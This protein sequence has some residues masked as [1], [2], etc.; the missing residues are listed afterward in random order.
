MRGL[1]ARTALAS[2]CVA[3]SLVLAFLAVYSDVTLSLTARKKSA[4]H[5]TLVLQ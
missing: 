2:E 4:L 3:R 5:G 1:R